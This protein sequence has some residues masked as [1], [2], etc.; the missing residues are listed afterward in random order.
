MVSFSIINVKEQT[1][2]DF[3]I[4]WGQWLL[5]AILILVV[6]GVCTGNMAVSSEM[7]DIKKPSK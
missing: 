7:E 5:V 1:P 2:V 4:Y 3:A 6:F